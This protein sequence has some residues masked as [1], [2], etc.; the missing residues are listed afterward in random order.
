MPRVIRKPVIVEAAGSLPKEIKEFVGKV[1]T[2]N[3][4]ISIAKMK[5]PAGWVE[6]GQVPEFDEYT[7]VLKGTLHI[8]TKFDDYVIQAG[9]AF[10]SYRNEWVQYST[11][12][13]EGA[14]YMAICTPAFSPDTVNRDSE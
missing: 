4:N 12:G 10:I 14:E 7:I 13:E 5:S 6:P 11:P 8:K 9:E 3:K 1:N 2:E